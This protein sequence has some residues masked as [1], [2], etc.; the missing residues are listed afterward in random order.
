METYILVKDLIENTKD[1]S[2][3]IQDDE[4]FIVQD[5]EGNTIGVLVSDTFVEAAKKLSKKVNVGVI[6]GTH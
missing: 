6:D 2:I 4:R 5:D 1:F 3:R